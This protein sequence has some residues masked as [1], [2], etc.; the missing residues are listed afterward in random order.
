MEKD[1][2]AV[3]SSP[4]PRLAW[5]SY[6]PL[7]KPFTSLAQSWLPAVPGGASPDHLVFVSD[8]CDSFCSWASLSHD[9]AECEVAHPRVP[10][11]GLCVSPWQS[12]WW[13]GWERARSPTLPWGPGPSRTPDLSW[14]PNSLPTDHILPLFPPFPFG[15]AL[16]VSAR[17]L[18]SLWVW[19]FGA[20]RMWCL[21][22][23]IECELAASMAPDIGKMQD[24]HVQAG[25]SG[26]NNLTSAG[27]L[28]G[29]VPQMEKE[30]QGFPWGH[31]VYWWLP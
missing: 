29:S 3:A 1:F 5:V 31:R 17:R 22:Q 27:L 24:G 4:S 25:I 14:M 28:N 11:P 16:P 13:S 8:E 26:P 21:I 20:H 9:E 12:I 2:T 15:W 23:F 18:V 30:R 10:M 6:C 7:F 19:G